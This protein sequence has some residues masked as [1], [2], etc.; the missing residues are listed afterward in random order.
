MV[1]YKTS[2]IVRGASALVHQTWNASVGI[3][4]M[5]KEVTYPIC[6]WKYLQTSAVPVT[7]SQKF[8]ILS[9]SNH[10]TSQNHLMWAPLA[11]TAINNH[12]S[13]GKK[14]IIKYIY[15]SNKGSAISEMKIAFAKAMQYIWR[16][17]YNYP[18]HYLLWQKR[19]WLGNNKILSI[20]TVAERP[21]FTRASSVTTD[22]HMC[23][24][25]FLNIFRFPLN[26]EFT[27]VN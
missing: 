8:P 12:R 24:S 4:C 14:R 15:H 10:A 3:E 6:H 26:A 27:L 21:S 16:M 18:M 5:N 19:N 25:D 11:S 17:T 23:W 13:R 1:V 9:Q 2:D 7:M 20:L 22:V